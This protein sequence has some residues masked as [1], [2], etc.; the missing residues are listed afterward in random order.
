MGQAQCVAPLTSFTGQGLYSLHPAMP[1]LIGH[2]GWGTHWG[3]HWTIHH[4]QAGECV[5]DPRGG[6]PGVPACRVPMAA[7]VTGTG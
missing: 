1:R 7:G 6:R 2:W 4:R 5:H 3:L